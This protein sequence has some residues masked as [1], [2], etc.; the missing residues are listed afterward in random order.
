MYNGP[1]GHL[2]Y[3]GNHEYRICSVSEAQKW[4]LCFVYLIETDKVK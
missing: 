2:C 3:T 1:P 4:T